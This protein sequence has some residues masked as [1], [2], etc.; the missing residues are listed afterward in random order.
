M[1]TIDALFAFGFGLLVLTS[2]VSADLVVN[3]PA[4]AGGGVSRASQ[5]WQDPGPNGNDLDGDAVCFADF[6]LPWRT[7]IDHIE[8][9]GSGACELGFQIEIW[10]QDP[11][12]IAYQP[13]GVFP[14]PPFYGPPLVVCPFF[15]NC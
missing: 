5:L 10:K 11:G 3:H 4:V 7:S 13:V 12:T 6:T 15:F 8:W 1:K 14:F 9:W 2:T